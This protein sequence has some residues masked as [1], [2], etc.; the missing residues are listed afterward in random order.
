MTEKLILDLYIASTGSATATYYSSPISIGSDNG[1]MAELWV[2]SLSGTLHGDGIDLDVEGSNDGV[3]FDT[4][5]P[6]VGL[7]SPATGAPSWSKTAGSGVT[8]WS[9]LRLKITIRGNT[10]ASALVSASIRT[11][12]AG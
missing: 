2:T 3:N 5:T 12:R 11:Y 6:V 10:S 1:A 7:A 4:A 9:W 8:A